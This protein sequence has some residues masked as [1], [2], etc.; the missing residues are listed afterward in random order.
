MR[1]LIDMTA[2]ILVVDDEESHAEVI[3]EGLGRLGH[4]TATVNSGAAAIARL[5]AQRF[6]VIVTDLFLGGAED[7][8]DVL[9]SARRD[10]PGT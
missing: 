9:R 1:K 5:R 8:L 7:G 3:A 2:E 10:S 6:D 4:H